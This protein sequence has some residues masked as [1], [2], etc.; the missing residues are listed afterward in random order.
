MDN[1]N[2]ISSNQPIVFYKD[3][4]FWIVTISMLG[5]ITLTLYNYPIA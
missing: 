3:I 5:I 1:R 4:R 2:S